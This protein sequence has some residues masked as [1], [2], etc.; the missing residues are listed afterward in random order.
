MSALGQKRTYAVQL[1]MSALG[2][3]RTS[4][5]TSLAVSNSWFIAQTSSSFWKPEDPKPD[6]NDREFHHPIDQ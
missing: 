3:Q 5:C 1:V 4:R 6:K 2:Q